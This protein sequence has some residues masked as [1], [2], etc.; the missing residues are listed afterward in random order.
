MLV[1]SATDKS[2]QSLR[3]R[4]ESV[5][6]DEL[7]NFGET[8]EERVV[9]ELLARGDRAEL[10]ARVALVDVL[11]LVVGPQHLPQHVRDAADDWEQVPH[12]VARVVHHVVRGP[13]AM[14]QLLLRL[15]RLRQQCAQSLAADLRAHAD[16][17]QLVDAD[18]EARVLD[19]HL[20][21]PLLR[22]ED[23]EREKQRGGSHLRGF[24]VHEAVVQERE[25][26]DVLGRVVVVLLDARRSRVAPQ[27]QQRVRLPREVLEV[28]QHR[29]L[30]PL[31]LVR[32]VRVL[33]HVEHV[34]DRRRVHLLV[35]A[36]YEQRGRAN[37]LEV[38]LCDDHI[39]GAAG[40]GS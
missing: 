23:G 35:L 22:Q 6:N 30:H 2:S 8:L 26:E 17:E 31:Q 39:F 5:G 11:Q 24:D 37:Q 36:G 12:A 4:I 7:P 27:K 38:S 34:A 25:L 15:L 32:T 33:H 19:S 10:W 18:G 9:A 21:G 29:A 20:A 13:Y 3:L 28:L 16:A 40:S 14:R 1:R